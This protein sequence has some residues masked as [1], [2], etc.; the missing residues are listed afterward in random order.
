[1]YSAATASF[2]SQVM[3]LFPTMSN[4]MQSLEENAIERERIKVANVRL[5]PRSI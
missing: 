5:M 4:D 2:Q 1:M 3:K